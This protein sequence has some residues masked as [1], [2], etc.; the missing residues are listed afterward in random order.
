MSERK[1]LRQKLG[2]KSFDWFVKNVY[3]DL[4]VP[5][6]SKASGEVRSVFLV[7]V[8]DTNVQTDSVWV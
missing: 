7:L 5:G 1:A 2:C 6:E 4:F 8:P 3:P